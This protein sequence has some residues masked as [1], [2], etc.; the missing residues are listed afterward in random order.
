MGGGRV[1]LLAVVRTEH[2]GVVDTDAWGLTRG[3]RCRPPSPI[4]T[5]PMSPYVAFDIW[6]PMVRQELCCAG[7]RGRV[8]GWGSGCFAQHSSG[9]QRLSR[10]ARSRSGAR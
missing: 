1:V 4:E 6:R 2:V 10:N 3:P 5:I 8:D 7:V 9:R